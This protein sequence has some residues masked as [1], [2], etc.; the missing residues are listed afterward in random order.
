MYEFL[1]DIPPE[2]RIQ[3]QSNIDLG[4]VTVNPAV[5]EG[6]NISTGL[7]VGGAGYTGDLLTDTPRSFLSGFNEMILGTPDLVINQ[8]AE[9]GETAGVI[10]P[11]VDTRNYL[12]RLFNSGDYEEMKK[13]FPYVYVGLGK[14][15]GPPDSTTQRIAKG[16]GQGLGLAGFTGAL[17]KIGAKLYEKTAPKL[18]DVADR[19]RRVVTD[20]FTK[21]PVAAA[22]A[23]AEYGIAGGGGAQ[24]EKEIFG[25]DTGSGALLLPLSWAGIKA[26]GTSLYNLAPTRFVRDYTMQKVD[27]AKIK[28]GEDPTSDNTIIGE[29]PAKRTSKAIETESKRMA[30]D[31]KEELKRAIEIQQTIKDDSGEELPMSIAEATGD[32]I[33][34]K[35]QISTES[36]MDPESAS[37]N[38]KRKKSWFKAFDNFLNNK[39]DLGKYDESIPTIIYDKIK[40]KVDLTVKNIDDEVGEVEFNINS[41]LDNADF[42]TQTSQRISKT[43]TGKQIQTNLQ[44]VY[45]NAMNAVEEEAKK[46]KINK[47]NVQATNSSRS[48]AINEVENILLKGRDLDAFAGRDINKMIKEQLKDLQDPLKKLTF[49]S[50]RSVN[51][52]LNAELNKQLSYGNGQ[53]IRDLEGF[54]TI[55]DKI[56]FKGKG[57]EAVENLQKFKD[58]YRETIVEPFR[59]A[60]VQ[61]VLRKAAGSAENAIKYD[62]SGE[63]VAKQFLNNVKNAETYMNIHRNNFENVKSI[64]DSFK[65]QLI[66][67]STNKGIIDVQKLSNLLNKEKDIINTLNLNDQLTD[68]NKTIQSLM[69]R[70][71]E[72]L[73]R[74]KLIDSNTVV[75]TIAKLD[76]DNRPTELIDEAIRSKDNNLMKELKSNIDEIA[77][78]EN[79]QG[80]ID[81]FNA[82]IMN[83]IISKAPSISNE[84]MGNPI[85]FRQFLDGSETKLRAA[86]GD[87]H[88][89]NVR[90]V[91]D[92][93]VKI[94]TTDIN[95]GNTGTGN[96]VVDAF[97]KA[98]GSSLRQVSTRA[99]DMKAGRLGKG[100]LAAY[101]M[102]R[103]VRAQSGLRADRLIEEALYNP[104]LAKFLSQEVDSVSGPSQKQLKEINMQLLKLGIYGGLSGFSE[105]KP[106]EAPN[107]RI[108]IGP[109]ASVA[110]TEEPPIQVAEI[111]RPTNIPNPGM[112]PNNKMKPSVSDLFPND[113]TSA[114]IE[115]RQGITS[116]V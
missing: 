101:F 23:E 102:S 58:F 9:L 45:N 97:E 25:T 75:K 99:M 104:N 31:N 52:N 19:V 81:A 70:Q 53:Q 93:M 43:E 108:D 91:S 13:V 111:Q 114:S 21:A 79:D 76:K 67:R 80:V 14:Y 33:G 36:K 65:D 89:D 3:N 28:R 6:Q 51:E 32:V 96:T 42:P 106:Q 60:S 110:P 44:T 107:I 56:K 47:T 26:I 10:P 105:D 40:N 50:W 74:K 37:K 12:N 46:L 54:I 98:T 115:K 112:P 90:L 64:Q 57:G 63:L 24:I 35:R 95:P 77:K 86:L 83:R 84:V 29:G 92:G 11:N 88:F 87:E 4:A 27:N 39:T 22:V 48:D 59:N 62:T 82:I 2:Q 16:A 78:Q 18:D 72:L 68:V 49:Q 71:N 85:L 30:A 66:D 34:R 8:I 61:K 15:A 103:G 38:I 55:W 41:V 113:A 7:N 116:L 73:S 1:K 94:L 100:T 17:T 20:R 5:E 109:G 69:T